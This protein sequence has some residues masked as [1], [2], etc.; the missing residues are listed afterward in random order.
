MGFDPEYFL[1]GNGDGD[2]GV[3]ESLLCPVCQCV[4]DTPMVIDP[5]GHSFCKE[6]VVSLLDSGHE[7]CPVCRTKMIEGDGVGVP[8]NRALKDLIS[9]MNIRCMNCP[10]T[11]SIDDTNSINKE[12]DCCSWTGKLTEFD[13]HAESDCLM[14]VVSCPI[15]GCDFEGPRRLMNQHNADSV[16]QHTD[17][18]VT[19]KVEQIKEELLGA[20]ATRGIG[21][22]DGSGDKQSNKIEKLQQRLKEKTQ[23]INTLKARL[24]DN[25]FSAFFKDWILAKPPYFHDFVVYRPIKYLTGSISQIIVGVPGPGNSDWEGGLYPLLITITPEGFERKE[26][27]KCDF[28]E[29]FFHPNIY[30]GNVRVNTLLEFEG[31]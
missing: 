15:P 29:N 27:P 23:E 19:A 21:S 1:D 30:E 20:S 25:W 18:L 26:P 31:S 22:T 10:S 2:V 8:P 3:A 24:L 12:K 4:Y 7:N 5:C 17:L 14:Q 16:A 28:P 13:S 9:N 11:G 6:C